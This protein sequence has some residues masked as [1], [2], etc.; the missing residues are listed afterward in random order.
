MYAVNLKLIVQVNWR[1][2]G[3]IGYLIG[4]KKKTKK[5]KKKNFFVFPKY[6]D[7]L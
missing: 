1:N 6:S 3:V 5:T 2:V 7:Q 4:F